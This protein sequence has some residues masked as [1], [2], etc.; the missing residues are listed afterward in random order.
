MT[1][2]EDLCFNFATKPCAEASEDAEVDSEGASYFCVS[3]PHL[4][5]FQTLF[6]LFASIQLR[7]KQST[8]FFFGSFNSVS[9][10]C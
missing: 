3:L 2:T 10:Y 8:Y 9:I 7:P 5:C 4:E 1:R 6:F